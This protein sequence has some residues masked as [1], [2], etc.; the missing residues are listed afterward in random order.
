MK[1]SRVLMLSGNGPPIYCGI[2]D[3]TGNLLRALRRL[4]PGWDWT[5]MCRRPRWF[6]SPFISYRGL[7]MIRPVVGWSSRSAGAAIAAARWLKPDLIHIQDQTH[8][9]FESDAAVLIA[10]AF[11]CPVVVTLHEFHEELAS[12]RFTTQLVERA[13]VLICNDRRTARRCLELCRRSPDLQAWSPSNVLTETGD[14]D[15]EPQKGL[16]TTFGLISPLKRFDDIH[17]ALRLLRRE[18]LDLSWRIVGP[19]DPESN[20]YHAGL[21]QRLRDPWIEFTGGFPDINDPALRRLLAET[22]A[23]VLPFE[24]GAAPSRGS[25]QAAWAFGLP[26]VTQ[27]PPVDEPEIQDGVNCLLVKGFAPQDWSAAIRQAVSDQPLREQLRA[28]SLATAARFSWERLARLHLEVYDR[29][30]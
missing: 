12:V 22:W 19:F 30:L 8:S 15:I 5:W 4:R 6:H 28:G 24:T 11:P 25:L 7:R 1:K 21:S 20:P 9:F 26:I 14:L 2:G 10:K 13:D 18:G 3:Y 27:H 17:A 16:L 23:A 29:L